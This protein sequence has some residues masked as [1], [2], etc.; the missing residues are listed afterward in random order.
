MDK[1]YRDANIMK[2]CVTLVMCI[3]VIIGIMLK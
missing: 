1:I 3:V 2:V